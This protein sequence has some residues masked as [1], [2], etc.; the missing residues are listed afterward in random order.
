LDTGSLTR[1]R[2]NHA[3][4]INRGVHKMSDLIDDLL[5]LAGIEAGVGVDTEECHPDQIL[6]EVTERFREMILDKGLVLQIHVAP[7]RC[8]AHP[9]RTRCSGFAG[10]PMCCVSAG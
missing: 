1:Q 9:H 2:R 10:T 7:Q 4:G 3:G 8:S 6:I 5:D